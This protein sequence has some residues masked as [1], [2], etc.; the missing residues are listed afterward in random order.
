[1]DDLPLM[2]TYIFTPPVIPILPPIPQPA[3]INLHNYIEGIKAQIQ[4]SIDTQMSDFQN[5]INQ[6]EVA[7]GVPF[8]FTG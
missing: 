7:S 5:S 2:P 4:S 6:T 1:M 3:K 8:R